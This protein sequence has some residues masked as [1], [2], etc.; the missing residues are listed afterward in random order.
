MNF[1]FFSGAAASRRQ[2]GA[3]PRVSNPAPPPPPR[4]S[5]NQ[6]NS[7]SLNARSRNTSHNSNS[8][9]YQSSPEVTYNSTRNSGS[10]NSYAQRGQRH[11]PSDASE[12]KP[13]AYSMRGLAG[14]RF[15]SAGNSRE[16]T[17]YT[18]IVPDNVRSGQQFQVMAG[19]VPMMVTCPPRAGPGDHVIVSHTAACIII[20]TLV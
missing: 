9:A 17:P 2:Q 18:V 16:T 13:G 19:G 11:E 4:V 6:T 14:G 8:A 1:L 10:G 12:N 3:Y 15:G 20:M 5:W 7:E